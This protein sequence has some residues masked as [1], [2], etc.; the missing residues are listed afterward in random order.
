MKE[1]QGMPRMTAA[2]RK[3]WILATMTGAFAMI[4]LDETVVSVALRTVQRD[5]RISPAGL[6][7][8]MNAYLLALASCVAVGGRL[9]ELVGRG[10]MF[11]IGAATSRSW[12]RRSAACRPTT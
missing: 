4:M 8:V 11:R 6:Q 1:S 2:N 3:W 9:S 12:A 5:L 10:R 7:W